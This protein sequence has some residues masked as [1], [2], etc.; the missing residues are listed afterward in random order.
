MRSMVEGARSSAAHVVAP[1]T[2]FG[3]PPPPHAGEES[4][5]RDGGARPPYGG[6][7]TRTSRLP[8]WLAG[9]T[10]PSCSMRSIRE[11]ARL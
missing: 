9:L 1:S 11:A 8:A 2:T 5:W 7:P 10:T 6:G 3:G 4:G